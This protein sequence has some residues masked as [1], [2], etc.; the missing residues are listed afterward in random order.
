MLISIPR[1]GFQGTWEQFW[2]DNHSFLTEWELERIHKLLTTEGWAIHVAGS[3]GEF[4]FINL[5]FT[6][7]AA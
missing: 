1:D 3:A 6:P 2:L 5:D 4:S 7:V